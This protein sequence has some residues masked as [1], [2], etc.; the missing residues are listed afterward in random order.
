MLLFAVPCIAPASIVN[1]TLNS[2][3]F[4]DGFLHINISHNDPTLISPYFDQTNSTASVTYMLDGFPLG[5]WTLNTDGT[6]LYT[7]TLAPL[8]HN[9]PPEAK[10]FLGSFMTDIRK[11]ESNNGWTL[12]AGMYENHIN[13]DNY[14][15]Y[16]FQPG[17]NFQ[18]FDQFTASPVPIPAA[19]WLMGSALLGLMGCSRRHVTS[20][21]V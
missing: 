8:W 2:D 11:W 10:L 20:A 3:I 14:A 13:P 5:Q 19:V 17:E 21:E 15:F 18:I 6:N 7:L 16:I 12:S 9:P 1:H 4:N